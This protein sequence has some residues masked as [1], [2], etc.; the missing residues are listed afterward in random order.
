MPT[1]LDRI[2]MRLG[3]ANRNMI[4]YFRTEHM[5]GKSQ[6]WRSLDQAQALGYLVCLQTN[7]QI[8]HHELLIL[9]NDYILED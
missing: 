7:G 2:L 5:L 8:N 9:L 6:E 3:E 1:E 4:N